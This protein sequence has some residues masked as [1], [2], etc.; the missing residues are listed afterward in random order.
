MAEV[1]SKNLW[2]FIET[3]DNGA[4]KNVGLELLCP[5]RELA[6]KQG[7]KLV[8][9][10]DSHHKDNLIFEFD[11]CVT[12]AKAAGFDTLYAFNGKSFDPISI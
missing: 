8:L 9:G 11:R 2:V 3:D 1:K 6:D 7:G 4:A 10:S 12:I 5:G